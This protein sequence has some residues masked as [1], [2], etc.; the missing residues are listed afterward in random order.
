MDKL[1]ITLPELAVIVGTRVAIGIGVGLLI[2]N[3]FTPSKRRAIG[4]PLFLAGALS[5]IP[6]AVHLFS[7]KKE[8]GGV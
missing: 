6:I 3:K 1:S 5:T 2:S 8:T 4:L 7:K